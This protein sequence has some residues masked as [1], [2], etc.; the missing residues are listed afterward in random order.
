MDAGA[1]V[2]DAG[3]VVLDAGA[4]V[5]DAGAVVLDAGAVVLDAGAVVLDVPA[6]ERNCRGM[7]SAS[8]RLGKSRVKTPSVPFRI[9]RKPGALSECNVTLR[10][11]K[12]GLPG[13]RQV[14][15][16]RV[17]GDRR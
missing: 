11:R 12:P 10:S 4:V 8:N 7:P 16:V 1:V 9:R 6:D 15:T 3:A 17:R 13:G 5:L 14:R 2:L